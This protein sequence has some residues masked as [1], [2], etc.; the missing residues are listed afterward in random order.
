MILEGSGLL[1]LCLFCSVGWL[2]F[3]EFIYQGLLR[4]YKELSTEVIKMRFEKE[5][6]LRKNEENEHFFQQRI[7]FLTTTRQQLEKDLKDLCNQALLGAQSSFVQQIQPL[8]SGISEK[9]AQSL[10]HQTIKI[11]GLTKPVEKILSEM[12]AQVQV[13]ETHRQGA[14]EGLKEQV[15]SMM[16]AQKIL[17]DE[18][19]SLVTALRTPHIRGCW[20]EMQLKRVV[21]LSG[22]TS[23]CDFQE[24]V[25]FQ[26][27]FDQKR[28][29]PD[30][31]IHLSDEKQVIVDAKAPILHYLEASSAK[32]HED[33]Q[34][35][36]KEH[37][38]LLSHHV[39]QLSDK[40]YWAF[41]NKTPEFVILFLPGEAFLSAALEVDPDLIELAAEKK[42]VLAT[43]IILIALL[44]TIAQGWRHANLSAQTEAIID[45]AKALHQNLEKMDK[46][47]KG[48]GKH[49][50]QALDFY[51][52][53]EGV[54]SE[55]VLPLAKKLGETGVGEIACSAA[56][57]EVPSTSA[58]VSISG[59]Y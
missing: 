14:Y 18:T 2:I 42:I 30:L 15:R 49:L 3:R 41:Q 32:N 25:V 37:A 7:D 38:R 46:G 36:L 55:K 19:Q 52:K 33:Y 47:M 40:E 13:L 8:L 44:K 31:I 5:H 12:V 34:K 48:V 58:A 6:L 57:K 11:E 27:Q 59:G 56:Q 21:E 45:L 28:K 10:N 51:H 22:M 54:F 24:Q 50:K 43:P 39:K 20:G 16:D 29:R 17:K 9:T 4:R 35:K 1:S 23:Y 26:D 53:N